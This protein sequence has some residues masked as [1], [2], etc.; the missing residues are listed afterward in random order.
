MKKLL[1]AP[2]VAVAITGLGA[3]PVFA[4]TTP[5]AQSPSAQSA[6][7]ESTGAGTIT[8]DQNKIEISEFKSTGLGYTVTGL[9]P[10]EE[11]MISG[12]R[13][14]MG[15]DG[16]GLL[17]DE[18]ITADGNGEYSGVIIPTTENGVADGITAT[19]YY[20]F[21]DRMGA[22]NDGAHAAFTVVEDS[23]EEPDDETPAGE[24]PAVSAADE[25]TADEFN[26]NGLAFTGEGFEP[27]AAITVVGGAFENGESQGEIIF[28]TS[29]EA[30]ADGKISGVISA[31]E[32]VEPGG[33]AFAATID[34]AIASNIEEFTVTADAPETPT[35]EPSTPAEASLSVSPEK[36]EAADFVNEKKGVALAV[37]NCEPGDKAH[38]VVTPKGLNVKAYDR[39]ETVG[40]DGTVTVSVYGNSSDASAYIGDYDVT[41]TCGDDTMT[42]DF[43][44]VADSTTGGDDDSDNGADAGDNDSN[45]EDGGNAG[46]DIEL[47][48]T[49][50]ELGGLVAG[51]ALLLLGGAAIVLTR[52]RS[53]GQ[54]PTDI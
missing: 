20:L 11:V 43:S 15:P 9:R 51:G 40:A 44:V 28:S 6:E 30:D 34:G 4:A 13:V 17:F 16:G 42:E 53:T 14:V 45:D 10:G 32:A 7:S 49:G 18:P 26:E 31:T 33:Y 27:G 46:G 3:A 29:V 5:P 35:D 50:I 25:I 52:R 24:D 23:T 47:P 1:L 39:T 12:G 22:E 19:D 54:F 37:E 21:V 38:F 48:R 2:A 36:I 8:L 41:V